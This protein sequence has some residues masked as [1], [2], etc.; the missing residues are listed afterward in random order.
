MQNQIDAW[1][2]GNGDQEGLGTRA[3]Q[4]LLL[5]RWLGEN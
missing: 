5:A 4:F 1:N 3:M 2:N